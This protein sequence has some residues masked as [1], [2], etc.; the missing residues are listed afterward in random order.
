MTS[1]TAD[2]LGTKTAISNSLVAACA[3]PTSGQTVTS[4]S[5]VAAVTGVS[6]VDTYN[7]LK[8]D[9]KLEMNVELISVTDANALN[10]LIVAIAAGVMG[11]A[12]SPDNNAAV[13]YMCDSCWDDDPSQW[14]S[15]R[16]P[17]FVK[18]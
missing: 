1:P 9:G 6:Y 12:Q 2:S 5:S 16:C 4:C 14:P 11:N 18:K 3:T 7:D 15:V 8:T 10:M 17:V 13:Q